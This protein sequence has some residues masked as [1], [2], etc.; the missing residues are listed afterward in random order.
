MS[1]LRDGRHRNN[2]ADSVFGWGI[3]LPLATQE[4][5]ISLTLKSSFVALADSLESV[6]LIHQ[7]LPKSN[8]RVCIG[9]ELHRAR[10]TEQ[11]R[12]LNA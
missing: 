3:C 4:L 7:N 12:I 1:L 5:S 2:T 6:C 8:A 11:R 9:V 10:Y